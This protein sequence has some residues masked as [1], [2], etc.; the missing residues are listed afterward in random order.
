M[1]ISSPWEGSLGSYKKKK[2]NTSGIFFVKNTRMSIRSQKNHNGFGGNV[3]RLPISQGRKYGISHVSIENGSKYCQFKA[4][5]RPKMNKIEQI[6]QKI[7]KVQLREGN[8]ATFFV[9]GRAAWVR[10][11]A[12][13][14][15]L[16][17]I[18]TT[19][20]VPKI[21]MQTPFHECRQSL[22]ML[23]KLFAMLP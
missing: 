22:A 7:D 8:L 20:Q 21:L 9:P 18:T 14:P 10:F 5:N 12:S 15:R 1:S 13:V 6:F 17:P 19:G 3:P 23:S 16:P 11:L 4:K 2:K